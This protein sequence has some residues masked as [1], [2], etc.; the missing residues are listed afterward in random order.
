MRPERKSRMK[1][2]DVLNGVKVIEAACD[3]DTEISGITRDSRTAERG[4]L[5]AA[6][7]GIKKDSPHGIDFAKEAVEKG[8]A[9][10]LCD[11]PCAP[12]VPY[13]RVESAQNALAIASQNFMG[14]PAEKL[15]LIGVTGTNGKTTVT[16]LIKFILEK[17]GKKCGLIGTIQNMAGDRASPRATP[18]EA[19]ELANSLTKWCALLQYVIM[20]VPTRL[21]WAECTG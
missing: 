18:R 2:K 21:R 6:I 7:A 17:S 5:F 4:N 16:N 3:L 11:L 1:L 20:E 9:C 15:K 12:G 14:R 10:V 8:A 19:F 13:V